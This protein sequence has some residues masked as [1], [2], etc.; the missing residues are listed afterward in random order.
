VRSGDPDNCEA[1]AAQL[2]F[3]GIVNPQFNRSQTRFYNTAL[4]YGYAVVRAAIA[5]TLTAYGFLPAFGLFHHSQQN[6][7]NLADDLIEPYRPFVDAWVRHHYP[8]EPRHFLGPADKARLVSLLHEDVALSSHGSEEGRCTVLAAIEATVAGLSSIVL[9]DTPQ[10]RLAFP[11]LD[12]HIG[13]PSD[14]REA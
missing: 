14:D 13:A 3:R 6:N 5:R 7:F 10:E 2:Y 1:Q 4:N 9:Q 11:C 12:V 8:E